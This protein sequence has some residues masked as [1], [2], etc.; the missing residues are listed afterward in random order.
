MSKKKPDDSGSVKPDRLARACAPNFNELAKLLEDGKAVEKA[1]A[2]LIE[3]LKSTIWHYD[4]SLKE[5]ELEVDGGTRV[6]AAQLLLAYSVGEPVKRQQILTGT[7]PDKPV[8]GNELRETINRKIA[9][10]VNAPDVTVAELVAAGKSLAEAEK[11]APMTPLTEA[12]ATE[13]ARRIHGMAH[14]EPKVT[15]PIP[16]AAP[17]T[18]GNGKH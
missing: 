18:N 14:E 2:T 4:A 11:D 3:L 9:A 6:K 17:I 7:I 16:S 13:E 8:D 10:R 12:E 1:V 15:V 5:W